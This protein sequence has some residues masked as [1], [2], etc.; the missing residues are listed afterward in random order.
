MEVEEERPSGR[1]DWVKVTWMRISPLAKSTSPRFSR[2]ENYNELFSLVKY[3]TLLATEDKLNGY[4]W[5]IHPYQ[6]DVCPAFDAR[7][8]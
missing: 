6:P 5:E 1:P 2:A 7:L 3:Y 8:R 4:E